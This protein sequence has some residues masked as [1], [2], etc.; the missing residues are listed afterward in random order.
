M[1]F[2]SGDVR[3]HIVSSKIDQGTPWWPWKATQRRR[4]PN[5][6]FREIFRVARFSTFATIGAQRT[7]VWAPMSA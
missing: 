1:R 7:L 4:S 5:I 6:N 2:A 3:D